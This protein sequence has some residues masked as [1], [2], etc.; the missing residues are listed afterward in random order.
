MPLR[1]GSH[2][3]IRPVAADD[4]ELLQ[5]GLER[6]SPESSYRR[7]LVPRGRFTKRELAYLTEIDHLDHEALVATAEDG[8]EPVVVA[9]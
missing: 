5:R 1:D 6:L 3:R 2:V 9:R 4:K 8:Q 7:F